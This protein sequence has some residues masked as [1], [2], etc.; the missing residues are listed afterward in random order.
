MVFYEAAGCSIVKSDYIILSYMSPYYTFYFLFQEKT[1]LWS[2]GSKF[3]YLR[4]YHGQ[5]DNGGGKEHCI[6]INFGGTNR[7]YSTLYGQ[8]MDTDSVLT[9]YVDIT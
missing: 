8:H 5:P 7:G 6:E 9:F 1:W 4:W 3:D 2:D